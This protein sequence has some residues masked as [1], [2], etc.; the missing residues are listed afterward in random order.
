M[1]SLSW[2]FVFEDFLGLPLFVFDQVAFLH[3]HSAESVV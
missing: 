3:A 1:K 2:A